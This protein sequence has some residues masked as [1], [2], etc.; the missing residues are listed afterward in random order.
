MV[1]WVKTP[2]C[3]ASELHLIPRIHPKREGENWIHKSVLLPPHVCRA[4]C[5]PALMCMHNIKRKPDLFKNETNP[6]IASGS[7]V[8]L[9][10]CL[11]AYQGISLLMLEMKSMLDLTQPDFKHLVFSPIW[12]AFASTV[13]IAT[14]HNGRQEMSHP[15]WSSWPPTSASFG[16]SGP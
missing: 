13:D 3:K 9:L 1:Q 15:S 8:K 5:T 11:H 7:S 4:T 6:K 14:Q 10:L 16:E 2:V 12:K